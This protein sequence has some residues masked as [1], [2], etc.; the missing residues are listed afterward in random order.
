MP[1]AGA[2]RHAVVWLA[3]TCQLAQGFYLPGVSPREYHEGERVELKVNKLTSTKTQS[4]RC[5]LV[6]P[7]RAHRARILHAVRALTSHAS[8]VAQVAV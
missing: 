1:I 5:A 7:R 6:E 8:T 3:A 2:S 4:A